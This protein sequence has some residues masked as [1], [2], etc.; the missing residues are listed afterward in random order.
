MQEVGYLIELLHISV[1]AL[2]ILAWIVLWA[3]YLL[4]RPPARP[5]ERKRHGAWIFGLILQVIGYGVV[6][7]EPRWRMRSSLAL[8]S[9]LDILALLLAAGSVWILF[10]AVPA[11][12]RQFGVAA[13]VVEGHQLVTRGPYALVRHPIYSGMT[14]MLLATGLAFGY[15][16]NLIIAVVIFAAGT[17]IRIWSEEKLLRETFGPEYAEYAR[18]VPAVIPGKFRRR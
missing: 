15:W 4:H 6:W 12:G 14:G 2:V 5:P 13:R 18:R 16:E 17:A 9:G 11:L 8:E 10:A 7:I 1:I 3:A